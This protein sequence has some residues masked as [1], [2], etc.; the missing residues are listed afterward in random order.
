MEPAKIR[1]LFGGCS[2]AKKRSKRLEE[3]PPPN[4]RHGADFG[5]FLGFAA[6]ALGEEFVEE[7]LFQFRGQRDQPL[8]LLDR[9]LHQPQHRRNLPLLREA[10]SGSRYFQIADA[11]ILHG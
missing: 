2:A 5:L 3:S 4:S 7:R 9:L 10:E 8:L 1:F 6:E 11:L